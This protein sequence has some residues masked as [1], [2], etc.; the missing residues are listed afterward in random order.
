M[1]RPPAGAARCAA[2]IHVD[3]VERGGNIVQF[4]ALHYAGWWMVCH[5]FGACSGGGI[6]DLR[7]SMATYD[8]EIPALLKE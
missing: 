1:A 8:C 3:R 6:Q 5:G 2:A 7:F 4:G